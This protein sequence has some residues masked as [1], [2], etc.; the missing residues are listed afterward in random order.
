MTLSISHAC[1]NRW[2]YIWL[3]I[4]ICIDFFFADADSSS[5]AR[6][7]TDRRRKWWGNEEQIL[8]MNQWEWTS[9]QLRTIQPIMI[10]KTKHTLSKMVILYYIIYNL[11]V[12][13][14][15]TVMVFCWS[16]TAIFIFITVVLRIRNTSFDYIAYLKMGIKTS[17]CTH[18]LACE[19]IAFCWLQ[20]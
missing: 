14:S 16:H 8:M 12:S 10:E 11:C 4:I 3:Y 15:F 9:W 19:Y 18:V 17:R 6:I 5:V 2:T 7:L 1:G 20:F 13:S